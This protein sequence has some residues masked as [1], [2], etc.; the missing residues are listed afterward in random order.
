MK[1]NLKLAVQGNDDPLRAELAAAIE[2]RIKAD[3]AVLPARARL[4]DADGRIAASETALARAAA[5]VTKAKARA[6]A[7]ASAGRENGTKEIANCRSREQA[8]VDAVEIAVASRDALAAKLADLE[9]AAAW[10][11]NAVIVCANALL[12]PAAARLLEETRELRLKLAFNQAIL[13]EVF[14]DRDAPAFAETLN[15]MLARDKRDA[16]LAAVKEEAG[17]FL[18]MMVGGTIEEQRKVAARIAAWWQARK[19]MWADADAA[20]PEL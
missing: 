13:A 9:A 2:R 12:A 17:H 16:P 1:P 19:Q 10:A 18:M 7:A 3:A 8:A 11:Q 20:L 15:A 5:D 14:R 4:S 6:V